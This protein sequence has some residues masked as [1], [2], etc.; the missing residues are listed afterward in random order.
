MRTAAA[1]ACCPKTARATRAQVPRAVTTSLPVDPAYSAGLQPRLTV[2]W[3]AS[4]HRTFT[5]RV[6]P[7]AKVAP[8]ALIELSVVVPATLPPLN[9]RLA[10]AKAAVASFA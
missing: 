10:P 3:P 8:F 9:A 4:A 7:F 2:V 6:R 1:P 5:G